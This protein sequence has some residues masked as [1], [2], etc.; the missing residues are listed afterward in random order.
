MYRR[1]SL[2]SIH[3]MDFCRYVMALGR[4]LSLVG[5]CEVL[6]SRNLHERN[7][8]REEQTWEKPFAG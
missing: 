2:Y 4:L 1:L 5:S 7:V 8:E 3:N 6:L